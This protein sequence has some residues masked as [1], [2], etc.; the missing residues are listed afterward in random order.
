VTCDSLRFERNAIVFVNATIES[1]DERITAAE[2][3]IQ[4]GKVSDLSVPWKLSDDFTV[5]FNT[6]EA[7]QRF[8]RKQTR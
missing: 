2:A 1:E 6:A 5:S 7:K 4:L 3:T 8:L